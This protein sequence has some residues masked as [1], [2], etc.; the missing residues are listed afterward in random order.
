MSA[1]GTGMFHEAPRLPSSGESGTDEAGREDRVLVRTPE[2]AKRTRTGGAA[3]FDW[4]AVTN[5]RRYPLRS[6]TS[7]TAPV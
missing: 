7:G 2:T 5:T 1:P 3:R 6:F 4:V